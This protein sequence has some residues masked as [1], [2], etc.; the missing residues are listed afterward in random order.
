MARSLRLAAVLALAGALLVGGTVSGDPGG[1]KLL[2]ASMTGIPS[3]AAS[4]FPGVSGGGLPWMLDKGDA[5]LFADG[6]LQV[7]VQGLVF[8]SGPNT[9]RNT[10]PTG[11]A[12]VSCNNGQDIVESS[13]VSYSVPEGDARVNEQIELPATCL[14]PIVFF[15]GV[16]SGGPRWFAV[17]GQ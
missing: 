5:R 10:I 13:T 8:A 6:R 9:G 1:V 12:I 7:T 15:A 11:R 4:L 16:T 14:G 3:G 17:T 2:D